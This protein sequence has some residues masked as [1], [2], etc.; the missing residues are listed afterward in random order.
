[1]KNFHKKISPF[2]I[3]KTI[4]ACAG[5][6]KQVTKMKCRKLLVECIREQQSKN[7]LNLFKIG[8]HKVIVQPHTKLNFSQGIIRDKDKDLEGLSNENI[9]QE[10]SSQGVVKVKRFIK[11]NGEEEIP[12]NTF[13]ITFDTPRIPEVILLGPYRVRVD[14]FVPNPIRCFKCQKFGHG[15][16]YC[17]ETERCVKCA[18]EGHSNFKCQKDPK[19][20]N[21]K[22]NHMS[23][24]KDCP[25][26]KKEAAIQKIKSEKNI[27][28]SEARR[29]YNNTNVQSNKTYAD[30][31]A[32]STVTIG[33]QT[34][35]TWPNTESFPK[36]TQTVLPEQP[37]TTPKSSSSSSQTSSQSNNIPHYKPVE[38]RSS[39]LGNSQSNSQKNSSNKNE[40]QY[41][42][43]YDKRRSRKAE[44]D[45]VFMYNRFGGLPPEDS[46]DGVMDFSQSSPTRSPIRKQS[47]SPIRL[48]KS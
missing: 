2:L 33:T 26:F 45:S 21:C 27:T 16:H 30:A 32:K 11:K 10:L 29:Q 46:E 13:L 44:K 36:K 4:Q 43:T 19:C 3:Q 12:L 15:S 23:S 24:S 42:K 20:V 37:P 17:E 35:F 18:E 9:C 31:A 7:L 41:K 1:M 47:I 38:H 14:L 6:V 8:E 5:E 39:S 34:I 22:G 48:P 25:A 40:K 28:Y